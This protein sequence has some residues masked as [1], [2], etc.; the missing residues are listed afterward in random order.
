M[1]TTRVNIGASPNVRWVAETPEDPLDDSPR[2]R[3]RR[4]RDSA[5]RRLTREAN[6]VA[7]FVRSLKSHELGEAEGALRDLRSELREELLGSDSYVPVFV[8]TLVTVVVIPL[9]EDNFWAG[10]AVTILA[11]A[12]LLLTSR[13]SHLK[14]KTLRWVNVTAL[15]AGGAGILA[16]TVVHFGY[17]GLRL[18]AVTSLVFA[19]LLALCIP[20]ILRRVLLAR[21]VTMNVLAG[22]LAAYLILGLFFACW[23]RFVAAANPSVPF[24]A[25]SIQPKSADFEYFSFITITTTGYGDLSPSS[26]L[27]RA[28]AVAEA[29]IGQVFLVTIVARVVSHLGSERANLTQLREALRDDGEDPGEPVPAEPVPDE[30]VESPPKEADS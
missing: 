18:T 15:L 29:I 20:A 7:S 24:F 14:V 28:S 22:A 10:I 25:Q 4:T 2:G 17:T 16:Q 8:L 19:V 9:S 30:S 27:A 6:D 3:G 13:R 1:W 23:F 12:T 11:V 21:K 26:D 5:D